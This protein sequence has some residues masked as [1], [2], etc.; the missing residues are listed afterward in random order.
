MWSWEAS[1]GLEPLWSWQDP[2]RT[3][4]EEKTVEEEVER[5]AEPSERGP[6]VMARKDYIPFNRYFLYTH[7]MPFLIS[8]IAN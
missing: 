3:G 1:R 2:D 4:K 6:G 8:T 7:I 5:Q